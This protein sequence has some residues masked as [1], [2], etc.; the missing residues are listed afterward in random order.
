MHS[1]DA[2][3]DRLKF[4]TG[5]VFSAYPWLHPLL[6]KELTKLHGT[7]PHQANPVGVIITRRCDCTLKS[8]SSERAQALAPEASLLQKELDQLHLGAMQH[9]T[10]H[11][12]I[13]ASN[14]GLL[15]D[16]LFLLDWKV[17]AGNICLAR[18]LRANNQELVLKLIH[19]LTADIIENALTEKVPRSMLNRQPESPGLLSSLFSW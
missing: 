10:I 19:E 9:G 12:D 16:R 13:K 11:L 2:L 6:K 1:K 14:I 5:M 8:M 7:S 4:P 3:F 18:L 15:G 17:A